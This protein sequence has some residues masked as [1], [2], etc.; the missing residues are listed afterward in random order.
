MSPTRGHKGAKE[1]RYYAGIV[2]MSRE[3]NP[4]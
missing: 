1:T 3:A 4:G 2:K